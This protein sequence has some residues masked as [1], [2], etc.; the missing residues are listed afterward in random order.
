MTGRSVGATLVTFAMAIALA[1]AG[2]VSAAAAAPGA[3]PTKSVSAKN[4]AHALCVDFAAWRAK[5]QS[6]TDALDTDTKNLTSI[7]ELKSR[8]STYFNDASTAT[9]DLADKLDAIGTPKVANGSKISGVVANAIAQVGD[10]FQSAATQVS[11]ITTTDPTEFSSEVQT[12]GNESGQQISDIGKAV[13]SA[14]KR[15]KATAF[16]KAEKADQ[17]CKSLD[18]SS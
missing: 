6:L 5:L 17:V 9:G 4:Y 10:A 12:I 3:V 14:G 16:N 18:S 2:L 11:G 8:T 7:D 1:V 15:F 13:K